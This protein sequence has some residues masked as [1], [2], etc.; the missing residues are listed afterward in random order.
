M[1]KTIKSGI[2]I[3]HK[4]TKSGIVLLI[5]IAGKCCFYRSQMTINEVKDWQ[6]QKEF[7][8]L[9]TRLETND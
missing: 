7:V 4:T 3:W 6:F 8:S 1:H 2:V 9:Q 5:D